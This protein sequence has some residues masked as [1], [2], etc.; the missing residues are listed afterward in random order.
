MQLVLAVATIAIVVVITATPTYHRVCVKT[1]NS[2]QLRPH[3]LN[4][5]TFDYYV[6]KNK[7]YFKSN[8]TF[9]FMSGTHLLKAALLI[10]HVQN[11]E[12]I[13]SGTCTVKCSGPYGFII[14]NSSNVRIENLTIANC[15]HSIASIA[16]NISANAALAF[17]MV[18]NLT[19]YGITVHNSRGFGIYSN[20][21]YSKSW[22]KSS[23]FRNNVASSNYSGG[24]ALI[25]YQNCSKADTS[26]ETHLA[27]VSSY[28]MHGYSSEIF[29]SASGLTLWLSCTNISVQIS[30][31]TFS[32]NTGADLLFGTGANLAIFYRNKTNIATNSVTVEN[33]Y[34]RNGH[35]N[36]GAGMYVSLLETPEIKPNIGRYMYAQNT[37]F[38]NISNTHFISNSATRVGA[39]LYIITHEMLGTADISGIITVQNCI[40]DKNYLVQGKGGSAFYILNKYLPDYLQHG[41]PQ[42]NVSVTNCTFSG[43]FVNNRPYRK[44][45]WAGG[46][47]AVMITNTRSGVVVSFTG[48]VFENN[49]C[50][51]MIAVQ[52]TIVFQGKNLFQNNTDVYGGGLVL[53]ENSQM[54]LKSHTTIAFISN[55]AQSVG[56]G[57]YVQDE[58]WTRTPTCFFEFDV[59]ITIDKTLLDTIAIVMTNNTAE[60]AGSALY[61]G[62]IGHCCIYT[63]FAW[64]NYWYFMEA[65]KEIFKQLFHISPNESS[66]VTSNPTGVCFCNSKNKPDCNTKTYELIKF[67]GEKFQVSVVVVGQMDGTVPG[68]VIAN[69]VNKSALAY[70]EQYIQEINDTLCNLLNYSVH[71]TKMLETIVLMPQH[72]NKNSISNDPIN[73]SLSLKPCPLGFSLIHDPPYCDCAPLLSK[74]SFQCNIDDQVI[75]RQS[76]A[77][78]MVIRPT[79]NTT[80]SDTFIYENQCP[81]SYCKPET[82]EVYIR[83]SN[84]TFDQ[85]IQCAFNYT[86]ILCRACEEGFSSILGSSKCLE[87]SDRYLLLLLAFAMAGIVFVFL[88]TACNLTV[89]EGTINGLM[90][91][92][93]IIY[94][95]H[96]LFFTSAV[97]KPQVFSS[98]LRPFIDW[99]NLQLGISTCFYD[100]MTAYAKAWLQFVFPIYLWMI[101]GAIIFLSRRYTTITRLMGRNAVKVLAT[102]FLISYA[103]LLQSVIGALSY[104]SLNYSNG[105]NKLVWYYDGNIGYAKGKHILLFVAAVM[106]LIFSLTYALILASVQCLRKCNSRICSWVP[107]FKPFFDAYT[108][109]YKDKYQFW[110][111]HL[112]MIRIVILLAYTVNTHG[113]PSVNLLLIISACAHLLLLNVWFLHGVYKTWPLDVLESSS[114]LNLGIL[115]AAT[116]YVQ[117]S[118]GNQMAVTYTSVGIAFMTFIGVLCYHVYRIVTSTQAWRI[119]SAWFSRKL[120]VPERELEPITEM[121][122]EALLPPDAITHLNLYREPQLHLGD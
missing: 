11:L 104:T 90:F 55:H 25:D 111:G 35:A 108:G 3:H 28:F 88:L 50:S 26:L 112:I 14:V 122:T 23:V 53:G 103:S 49:N 117:K 63:P 36:T 83:T 61:G 2:T 15:G 96:S 40:F 74:H 75:L 58:N 57:I 78:V 18:H 115:S 8:A 46:N 45:P 86:G 43:S 60:R 52:S 84:E 6:Q 67:P 113:H 72:D 48:C 21:V 17:D 37:Q 76:S 95:N 20:R 51:A 31:V 101:A 54:Y 121:E 79:E 102:L 12:L 33:C 89:T 69:L 64:E 93:N 85:N 29:P 7:H 16:P 114:F 38:L 82:S 9:V 44:Q 120:T 41:N 73:I 100:G 24:N 19:I 98:A 81:P 32:H 59:N 70:S 30:N 56:G 66:S 47:G 68:W 110:T 22:I 77:W 119:L 92:C 105:S 4:C 116:A 10:K 13:G 94:S 87:C 34:I 91:Y 39:G 42:F 62:S 106:V 27:I 99:M 65:Q 5:Q 107:R 1:E 80:E 118:G 71:S 97:M 109:S